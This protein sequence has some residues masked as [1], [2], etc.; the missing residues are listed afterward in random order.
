MRPHLDSEEH[1]DSADDVVVLRED[2]ALA[3][4]HG[5]W[6][7]AL[8]A[9][10]HDGIWH[11]AAESLREEL[12][13]ADVADLQA[14]VLSGDLA[15]PADGGGRRQWLSAHI[16]ISIKHHCISISL[17]SLPSHMDAWYAWHLLSRPCSRPLPAKVDSVLGQ[18]LPADPVVDARDGSEGFQTQLQVELTTAQV[19]DD[20]DIIAA[21]RKMQSSGPAAVAI[22]ACADSQHNCNA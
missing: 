3:V 5:V 13:V 2:R 19:V 11:E 17:S 21:C 14:D 1:V 8:L 4:N 7:G 12:P 15:P 22:T 18:C 10:V 6:R 16:S 20:A 9:K